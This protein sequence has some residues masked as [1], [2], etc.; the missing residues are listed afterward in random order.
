MSNVCGKASDNLVSMMLS[1]GDPPSKPTDAAIISA[2]EEFVQRAF[3]S[4]DAAH[5]MA[6]LFRVRALALRIGA[7]NGSDTLVLA[8][9]ALLHDVGDHKLGLSLTLDDAHRFLVDEAACPENVASMVVRTVEA[10]GFSKQLAGSTASE[11]TAEVQALQ[12]ADYLDAIGAVGIARVFSFGGSRGRPIYSE[13]EFAC[14]KDNGRFAPGLVEVSKEVYAD[15]NRGSS[16]GH[17]YEKL[18]KLKDRIVT[19]EG[20]KLATD[21]HIFMEHFLATLAAEALG[22]Q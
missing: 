17:F 12:D 22:H 3:A 18:L 8:L 15:K 21:R 10:I 11:R 20:R 4:A 14:M 1:S 9:A 2:T 5:D 13:E 16:V 19:E 6:H 7:T